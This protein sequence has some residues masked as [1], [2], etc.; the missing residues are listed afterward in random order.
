[1]NQALLKEIVAHIYAQFAIIPSDYIN[2]QKTGSLLDPTYLLN[3]KI[4]F[5]SEGIPYYGKVWGCQ[6]SM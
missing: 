6:M 3:D 1:M 4:T 5:E 2:L